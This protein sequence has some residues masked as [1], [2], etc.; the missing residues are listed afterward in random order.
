MPIL[1]LVFN[2]ELQVLATEIRQEKEIKDFQ[3]GNKE[4][5]L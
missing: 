4:I 2:T 1:T 5:K 3:M